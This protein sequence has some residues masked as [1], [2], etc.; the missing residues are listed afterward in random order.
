MHFKN[1]FQDKNGERQMLFTRVEKLI[2]TIW[3]QYVY[4]DFL[5]LPS[6]RMLNGE[7][8]FEE[9][10]STQCAE[11]WCLFDGDSDRWGSPNGNVW[12]QQSFTVPK[13]MDGKEL[14]YCCNLSSASGWY[15]GAPQCLVYVNG[16]AI[17]GMDTNH[18]YLVLSQAAKAGEKYD[19]AICAF[20]NRFHYQ[21]KVEMNMSLRTVCQ[22]GWKLYYDVSVPFK[23]AELLDVNDTRRIDI[24]QK[25]NEAVSLVDFRLRGR[26]ALPSLERASA[27]MDTTF[28]GEFCGHEDLATVSCVGHTHIDTAWLW[29]LAETRKKVCRSFTTATELLSQYAN[30]TFMSSQ[31]QLYQYLKENLPETYQ[32]VQDLVS[33]GKWEVEGGMWVE[34]D[35]NIPS[36]ES[37]VRQILYGKKFFREEFGK[38][39]RILWLPDVFGYSGALP[40]ILKKSGIDYFM[41]TKISW[42]EYDKFPYDTFLWRGIDGSEVLTHFI[43]AQDIRVSEA[44]ALTTYNGYLDPANVMGCWRRYQQKDINRDILFAYGHGDGGG[45]PEAAMVENALRMNRG[46]PGCPK[47]EMTTALD[48]FVKLDEETKKKPRLPL[49]WGELYFEYHRGTYTSVAKIKKNMRKAEILLKEAE[50]YSSVDSILGATYPTDVLQDAWHKLLLNQFHDII[51]GSSIREV[52]EESDHQ[53]AQIQ[54][55]VGTE[56]TRALSSIAAR[57]HLTE[58]AVLV[59]ND[60]GHVYSG[61]IEISPASFPFALYDRDMPIAW[62][63]SGDKVVAYVSDIPANGYKAFTVNYQAST[64]A[65]GDGLISGNILENQYFR[66][67]LDDNGNISSW[68]DKRMK[69]ELVTAGVWNRLIAFEDMP[70]NDDAWN[71]NAYYTE[72]FWNID[73]LIEAKVVENGPLQAIIEL[74]RRF[75]HSNILQ[76][77]VIRQNSDRID[78]EN[79]WDWQDS[80]ILVKAEF[81][82]PVNALRATFDIQFGNVERSTTDN[83]SWDFAQFEVCAHRWA[84]IS[85]AGMGLSILND[86]KYGYDAKKRNIRITLLKSAVYPDPEGD[87][88]RH[89]FTYSIY[90]HKGGWREADT[91]AQAAVLNC[92]PTAMLVKRHKGSL[93]MQLAFVSIDEPNIVV[94][95][96]KKAEDGNGYI[97]RLHEFHN[98][99]TEA[100][101][102]FFCPVSSAVLCDMMERDLAPLAVKEGGITIS[103]KPYEIHSVRIITP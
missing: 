6:M 23:V 35:T 5:A 56:K 81:P 20:T 3:A 18:R 9:A 79:I 70:P 4:D 24:L 100:V 11:L 26:E 16:K 2:N 88:G 38:D 76:R 39:N 75:M 101:L 65:Q 87:K 86:C 49:W 42:N 30:M 92:P 15:W 36:G 90:P 12:F 99:E 93:P 94:D 19:I 50:D 80:N 31:P 102:N 89:E 66:V 61:L 59:F 58:D 64:E 21:G 82:I 40:Q 8:T 1:G 13:E 54:V 53:F 72:K 28:Y 34:A 62:Q 60:S 43:C 95:A 74:K 98:A 67:A 96:F 68:F 97:L 37:L 25:L 44:E 63:R 32:K 77:L 47:V 22:E 91:V 57:V 71:I 69:K 78:V 52:Y 85:D 17:S 51:P 27:Y 41:T 29:T 46:I 33:Q 14:H 10:F 7:Y 73:T 45:G 55:A 83:N 84:D 48:Y 103:F